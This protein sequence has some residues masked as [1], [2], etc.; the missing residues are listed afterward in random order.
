MRKL[1]FGI[2]D[3]RFVQDGS[4]FTWETTYDDSGEHTVTVTVSD[5]VDTVSQEVKITIENVNR[6]PVILD[7]VQK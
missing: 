6:A 1:S 3:E 4:S 5:G 7:I 2:D